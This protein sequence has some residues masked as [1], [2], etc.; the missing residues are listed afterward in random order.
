MSSKT[1]QCILENSVS[2]GKTF[3]FNYLS[4]LIT[5]MV[6]R[7]TYDRLVYFLS[8]KDKAHSVCKY[9]FCS[10]GHHMYIM[11]YMCLDLVVSV[12]SISFGSHLPAKSVSTYTSKYIPLTGHSMVPL[13][14]ITFRY[15]SNH[16]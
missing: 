13:S 6:L 16:F 4:S 3:S 11:K 2:I 14:C 12:S 5:G 1:F 10:S 9:Y 7:S 8:D 15:L